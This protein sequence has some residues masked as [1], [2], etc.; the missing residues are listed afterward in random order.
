MQTRLARFLLLG[1]LSASGVAAGYL[2]WTGE[3]RIEALEDRRAALDRLVDRIAP[4]AAGIAGAQ[5]AY[6]D[7]GLRDEATFTRVGELID[8][9]TA[10]AAALRSH[11]RSGNAAAHLEEFWT[12]LS[13][14]SAAR[15]QAQEKLAVGE[16][17]AAADL[18]LASTR[19]QAITLT[20]EL[21]AFRDAEF[22]ALRQE[23]TRLTERSWMTLA[24]VAVVWLAGLLAL[25]PLPRRSQPHTAAGIGAAPEVPDVPT[26]APVVESSSPVDL[27]AAADL[28]AAILR[29]TDTASLPAILERAAGILDA[30][31]IIIWMA[32]GDELFAATAFG[33]DPAVMARLPPI[34]GTAENATA[35]A[36][37][38]AGL[39]TV[40]GDDAKLG[41]IVAPMPGPGGC[42]GVL[43]AEVRNGRERDAATCAVTSI[44]ASQLAA[45][46][47]PA[48]STGTVPGGPPHDTS[49]SDRHPAAS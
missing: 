13:E 41:A 4:A 46:L 49:G 12:A 27:A 21:R 10:E 24:G 18:L 33:Y 47:A 35:T 15:A 30:R 20:A 44:L 31:G 22:K 3:R 26:A 2:V 9:L 36:W 37:R 17:L 48:A 16:V 11:D 5:N 6:T 8:R 7:S 34:L 43:A 40:P 14:L 32:A 28:C 1:L 42:V 25:A 19:P 23:R 29:V 38:T 39:R 45:I